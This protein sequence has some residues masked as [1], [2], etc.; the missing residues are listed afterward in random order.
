M[1]PS[2]QTQQ[3]PSSLSG[4]DKGFSL[5]D[6]GVDRCRVLIRQHLALHLMQEPCK[7]ELLVAFTRYLVGVNVAPAAR[8]GRMVMQAVVHY[9]LL[10]MV[11]ECCATMPACLPFFSTIPSQLA[12]VR[13]ERLVFTGADRQ[14]IP[15]TSVCDSQ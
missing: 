8:E 13:R 1:P 2:T 14:R 9:T 11:P 10:L 7:H 3:E 15:Y 4:A 12:I 5:L 6:L